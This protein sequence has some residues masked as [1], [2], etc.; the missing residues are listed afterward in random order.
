M[1][2]RV[3]VAAAALPLLLVGTGCRGGDDDTA[4]EQ[5]LCTVDEVP[6]AATLRV[7][8]QD[9]GTFVAPGGR[10]IIPAGPN[11]ILGAMPVD[12]AVHPDGSVAYVSMVGRDDAA[13]AV[14]DLDTLEV[15]QVVDQDDVHTGLMVDGDRQRLYAAGGV[16]ESVAVYDIAGDG[17]LAAVGEVAIG[18]TAAGLALSEDGDTL[19]A[20]AYYEEVLTA[21]DLDSL[22]AVRSIEVSLDVWDLVVVPGRDEIYASDLSSDGIVVVD[23]AAGVEVATLEVATSPAG[24]AVSA[25]GSLVYAAVSNGDVVAV[26]DTASREVVAEVNVAEGDLLDDDGAPL[27]NSN[28]DAVWLDDAGRR[29][30]AARGADHAV[31]VLDAGTLDVLGAYPVAMVPI[32]LELAPDGR[33]VVVEY[34]GGGVDQGSLTAVDVDELDLDETTEEVRRLAVSPLEQFP[35]ECDGFFPIPS[36]EGQTSPIEHVVLVVKE[37]KTFD[38]LFGDLGA[39]LDVDADPAYQRWPAELTP[40][41]RALMSEFNVSDNFYVDARE[42]DSGHLILTTTHLTHYAEWMWLET[43]RNG[44]DVAWPMATASYPSTGTFFAHLLDHGKTVRVYGEIVGMFDETADGTQVMDVSDLD[45]PGGAFINFGVPDEEKARYIAERIEDEGLADFTFVSLPNDH[46]NGTLAGTPTPESMVADN[47]RAVGLLVEAISRS[48]LWES[49]AIFILQDDPQSCDDHVND[50]RSHLIVASP[51]ARRGYVSHTNGNFLAVFATIERILGVPPVGRPD[52]G[53]TPLW[54]LFQP[55]ADTAPFEALPRVPEEINPPGAFGADVAARLDLSG[56]DRDPELTPL[57]DAYLLWRM[58]RI[59]REEAERRL[60]APR[61]AL[62]DEQW[63]EL[64]EEAE[65]ESFAYDQAWARFERWCDDRGL[66]PPVRPVPGRGVG[67]TP[68]LPTR[69]GDTD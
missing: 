24:L 38:C 63:E 15:V 65:E 32:D 10:R 45:Y 4:P 20:G 49:T 25:D 50:S 17:T 56:P 35:F 68:P 30:Y 3:T 31:S 23:L 64:E 52:A 46:T 5:E 67:G 28:V 2:I 14:V 62:D 33:L 60:E 66:P 22:T 6:E 18:V 51:W 44:G 41:Q 9:D 43:D 47:D 13:V 34:R 26:I 55:V 11:V 29:L 69:S 54:D 16:D 37:N 61:M 57:L 42:S 12:V 40:N 39:D 36:R 58:G 7:G 1:G 27:L 53:A 59:T 8:W 48:D 19:W 21:I